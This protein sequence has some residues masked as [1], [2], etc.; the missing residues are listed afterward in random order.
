VN[1]FSLLSIV[2]ATY[3]GEKYLAPQLDSLLN[4]TYK[5]IEIII[6]DDCST[7]NTQKIIK[8]YAE[9]YN[10]ISYYFHSK[11]IGVNKNF[12]FG[13][14]KAKGDFIAIADQDDIWKPEK[15]ETQ[16]LQ[17]AL[18]ITMLVHSGSVIF[19]NEI[20]PIHKTEL[21]GSKQ[22]SGNDIK[23]L[24]LRNTIAG[25]NIIFRKELLTHITPIPTTIFYDWWLCQ[26]ATC[27]G[28]ILAINK[29]LA[30]QRQHD[31]NVTVY[32]RNT[33]KQTEKE[34]QER[35]EAVKAFLTIK[36]LKPTD[37]IFIQKLHNQLETLKNK[38]F[39]FTLFKFLF[40]NRAVFFY[41][42]IKKY[43]FFSQLKAAWRMSFKVVS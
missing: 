2:V 30:Y 20:L 29:V 27:H 38:T 5:N 42:K 37:K 33:K 26:V 24:L 25:H 22:M 12:E 9:K 13:F 3:N 15:I 41:Y 14:S 32:D 17:F 35:L 21:N 28:N 7:D 34:Y 6:C 1:T 19:K 10:N 40:A 39:S 16:I 31:T 23:K 11:N 36:A 8:D 4:Q 18:P 43:P